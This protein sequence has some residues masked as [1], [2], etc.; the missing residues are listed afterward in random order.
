MSI[1]QTYEQTLL[2]Q[3]ENILSS[4]SQ[5]YEEK[6]L[7]LEACAAIYGEYDIFKYWSTFNVTPINTKRVIEVSKILY[8]SIK[9]TNIPP[10]LVLSSLS[11]E[12]ITISEKKKQGV[13]YTDFRLA[14]FIAN[15]CNS[16]LNKFSSV[17]DIA[18]GSGIL[19]AAIAENYF[20]RFN[21]NYDEWIANYVFA[22]DLSLNALRCARL[23]L[24]VHT[25]SIISLQKMN[26]NWKVCDS[27]LS[28]EINKSTFDIIVGNPPWKKVKLLLHSFV[29]DNGVNHIYGTEYQEYDKLKYQENKNNALEYS[30][31]LKSCYSLLRDTEPDLYMAFL[32][33]ALL[34][35]KPNGHLSY[36]VPAGLIRSQGTE[37][38]RRYLL[39][40]SSQLKYYL[41]D[42]K[43]L[44]F[45]IDSRFKFI[46]ISHDKISCEHKKSDGF[47]FSICTAKQNHIYCREDIYFNTDELEHIRKDLTIPEC[48][49]TLEKDLFFKIYK[50]GI[51]WKNNWEI[52]IS[53]EVD[54]T[55][56]KVDFY[57]NNTPNSIPIIEGRMVQQY[58]FGAKAY[59]SG[60]GRSAKWIPCSG[61]IKPQFYINIKKINEQLLDR[62]TSY[63]VGY[64]DIAG[65]TNER[66]MMSAIIPPYVVCG[67]KV[68]TIRFIGDNSNEYMY[69]WLGV[70][71]SF[72]FDWLLRRVISTTANYFL[73]FSVPM[74]NINITND[75]AQKIISKS[76]FLT[77]MGAEFY[78]DVTMANLR[79]EIDI[80]VALAFGLSFEDIELIMEDFPLLDRSQ[81]A[82]ISEKRS[83]VTKDL[84]LS[85]A[86][87]YF[88][89]E[90]NNYSIR[91]KQEKELG[92]KA[93]I[94]SEM[95]KLI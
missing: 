10:S 7:V 59:I 6:L 49:N 71:N 9:N 78:T 66:T 58:R 53:R 30:K 45:E 70:S 72:V 11:R 56:N 92:A 46:I 64:C 20:N 91:Y 43:S 24:S 29:S 80:L 89:K 65:Q 51:S 40:E 28:D 73:L 76:K 15:D 84:L 60:S 67:N 1:S 94:P 36:I 2:L 48:R 79:A 74:P 93:Y 86:A 17:A 12:P 21:D 44:F 63:R 52:D 62:I 3:V 90:N 54:M 8:K 19:L 88:S 55:N 32:Q 87:K 42:N 77:N 31:K 5:E 22:Y 33:K 47:I 27:L 38:L 23:S 57:N 34:L 81:Q 4:F 68:P 95:S 69:F 25:K 85:K 26:S 83:T 18:V 41:L 14:L 50:N 13:Y 61:E 35:L 37:K 82:L 75:I 39:N 16:H